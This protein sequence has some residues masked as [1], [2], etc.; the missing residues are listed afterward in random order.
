MYTGWTSRR[1]IWGIVWFGHNILCLESFGARY[2]AQRARRRAVCP[3]WVME[4]TRGRSKT[5]RLSAAELLPGDHIYVKRRGRFYTHHGIYTGNGEVIHFTGSIREKTDPTVHKTDLSAFLKGGTLQRHHYK[6]RSSASKTI[7]I[8]KEQL[9]GRNYS[10]LW[11]NCEHFATYCATG[12]RK[13]I[14]VRR[15][16]S[17]LGTVA[18]GIAIY[19]FTRMISSATRKY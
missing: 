17:G 10:T 13:S 15:V 18:T 7:G 3:K 19:A 1:W 9:F 16:I 14:Q 6:E 11:N 8:A 2:R 4:M 12:R 5:V